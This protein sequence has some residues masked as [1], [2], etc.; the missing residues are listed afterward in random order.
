MTAKGRIARVL[1]ELVDVCGEWGH[2]TAS[3][4]A[5]IHQRDIVAMAGL[6]RETVNRVLAEWDSS[7]LLTKRARI[8][9]IADPKALEH[10]LAEV[11]R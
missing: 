10:E 1:L 6:M 5:F 2:Q 7:G 4:P 11:D 3:I 9:S 8:S